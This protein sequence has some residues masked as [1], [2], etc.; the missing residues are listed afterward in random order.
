MKIAVLD[1][2]TTG[3]NPIEN[4]IT[5]IGIVFIDNYTI[6][7]S[8]ELF[9]NPE[10]KI[11]GKIKQLTGI[12]DAT[13]ASS[14]VFSDIAKQ[15]IEITNDHVI[16]G[17][18]VHFDYSFLKQEM[19]RAGYSFT[20]KTL[21][22]SELAKYL[23]SRLNSFSLSSL[24]KYYK[25][26]NRRP[27]RALPDAEATASLFLALSAEKGVEF[28]N[29]LLAP[30][31]KS[32]NVPAHLRETVYKE[33][34]PKPGVYYFIDQR[35]K[36]VYIGKAVNLRSRVLSHFR[37][38]GNSIGI[39]ALSQQIRNIRY[40][41][42]GNELLAT[43]LEDHEIRHFWPTLNRAQ[44][45][46]TVRFGVVVYT[47]QFGRWRMN[48]AKSGKVHCF[49]VYF[50]QY[51][52]AVDFVKSM[53][54]KYQLCGFLCGM[55]NGQDMETE[56]HQAN[57]LKMILDFKL[58]S[59]VEIY[60]A[61]GRKEGEK[62]FVWIENNMYKGYGFVE[63]AS[64]INLYLLES[65]LTLRMSSV[66]SEAIIRKLKSTGEPSLVLFSNP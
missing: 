24:C 66:T 33:L 35:G 54:N 50:H 20:R 15:I 52:L 63:D 61:A 17:H 10:T 31:K 7:G 13:V 43:L 51:Y 53:M 42:T 2:E 19:K 64:E 38:E 28:I 34:P 62:S 65:K 26:Q 6:T 44:K 59:Q 22:T 39:L 12:D 5:E 3:L 49:M 21:C 27:H 29:Q 46:N 60:F 30:S 18:H 23:L 45:K 58:N 14:P 55:V 57:F 40:E 11:P 16:V 8:Y 56:I 1:I 9:I 37:G 41:E 32:L 47:D 25:I 4:R 36:P 48:I